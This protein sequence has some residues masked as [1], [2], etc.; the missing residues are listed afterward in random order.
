MIRNIFAIFK[1][2]FFFSFAV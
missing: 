1:S 2:A